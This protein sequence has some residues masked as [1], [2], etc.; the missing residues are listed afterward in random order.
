MPSVH[1]DPVV[2]ESVHRGDRARFEVEGKSVQKVVHEL[3]RRGGLV[4]V[5]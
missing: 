2:A 5:V 3:E 1:L 4:K